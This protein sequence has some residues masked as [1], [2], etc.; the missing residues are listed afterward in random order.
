MENTEYKSTFKSPI[1]FCHLGEN[2]PDNYYMN[3]CTLLLDNLF[4]KEF[5]KIKMIDG[6]GGGGQGSGYVWNTYKYTEDFIEK[7]ISIT[8]DH[9]GNEVQIIINYIKSNLSQKFIEEINKKI[10][11]RFLNDQT[12]YTKII[13]TKIKDFNDIYYTNYVI[14]FFNYFDKHNYYFC[15]SETKSYQFDITHINLYQNNNYDIKTQI[16]V[17]EYVIYIYI[18]GFNNNLDKIGFEIKDFENYISKN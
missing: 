11:D 16:I 8:V 12:V 15:N 6:G 1:R 3:K 18:D 4:D 17:S 13:P 7:E 9:S 14:N 5:Y 2:H 10:K